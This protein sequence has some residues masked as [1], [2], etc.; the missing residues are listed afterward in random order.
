MST[1]YVVH[2][3][4]GSLAL[5]AG[6]VALYSSKGA[7]RHRRAGMI[8]VYAMLTMCAFGILIAAV[9]GVAPALNIPSALLTASLV[10]T[11]LTTVRPRTAATERIDRIAMVVLTGIAAAAPL[12][13]AAAFA[14]GNRIRIAQAY[15]LLVFGVIA[16]F[17]AAGDVRVLRARAIQGAPRLRRHLWRMSYAMFVAAGSFFLGQ[18]KVFP[19]PM[20]IPGLLALP[21]LAVLATMFWWLWRMRRRAAPRRM[22]H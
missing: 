2:I 14:S 6:Y 18:A 9:R 11:G 10:A 22:R 3:A 12:V 7:P 13:A 21:V 4:A 15:P 5:V 8:F 1:A 19:Q 16:G 17:A 20:R